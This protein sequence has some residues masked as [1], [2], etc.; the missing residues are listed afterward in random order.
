MDA[1]N[2][3]PRVLMGI[4][5]LRERDFA[6]LHKKRVGLITNHTGR[7]F[8]RIRTIDLLHEAPHVTL[9]AVFA[10]EHGL[11][12]SK[13]AP[14]K[15]GRDVATGRPVYSLYGERHQPTAAQLKGIDTL[16]FDV[17][18]AGARFYTYITTLGLMMESAAKAGIDIVVLDRPN[19]VG[20][21][22]IAGPVRDRGRVSFIAYHD[23]PVQHGMTVGELSRMYNAER[24]IGAKLSVIKMKGWSREMTWADSELPWPMPS[25]NL[26]S[27]DQALLYPGV[28]LLEA[29]NVSVGRGTDTPFEIVGAPWLTKNEEL[30]AALT[31]QGVAVSAT[32]FVPASSK[33]KG[34]PCRGVRFAINDRKAFDAIE[35]GI[36]L[37]VQLRRLHAAQWR[38]SQVL[39]LLG[40]KRAFDLL[41]A[42]KG[43]DEIV[44]SWKTELDA[45][46][47]RRKAFLL[48]E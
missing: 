30:A 12:G 10:P 5:V 31:L 47:P 1:V 28:A 24:N 44:A 18:D 42:G 22:R 33:H 23:I 20:G 35:L 39:T 13:D 40:H 43:R 48:Y 37:A 6:E 29:T 32:E 14:I 45:F 25:P 4:D 8:D 2:R 19:P 9:A 21:Q 15:D 11:S 17:Q 36:E 41:I 34:Q 38:S 7:A 16:V 26:R 27:A 3:Q 46:A